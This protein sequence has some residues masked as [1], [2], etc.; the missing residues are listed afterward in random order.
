MKRVSIFVVSILLAS[1]LIYAQNEV[2]ALRYSRQATVGTARSV[3]LAGAIGAIGADFSSLSVNPAGIALYRGSELTISPSLF[4]D[5]TSSS[6]LGNSYEES[7]YNFNVGNLG[8][9][10][11]YDFNKEDGWIST[12]FGIGYNRNANFN[13][14]ILMSGLNQ[15][16]SLLDN[17]TDFANR[18]PN[19]L[20][21]FYEQLA[22]DIYLLPFDT[23]T[24]EFWNDIQNAGYGQHQ[25]R[26]LDTRGSSGEYTFSFG[27]NYNHRLYLGATFGI[28]R[29]RYEQ[30][31]IHSE[32]DLDNA[33]EF[34]DKFIFRENLRTTGTGYTFKLGG[35]IRPLDFLR[36]GFSY[37]LPVFYN[38]NDRFTT[39]MEG[40]YDPIENIQPKTEYSPLGDYDYKLKTPSKFVA[41][42]AATI[43][44]IGLVSVDYERTDFS[45]A[46]LNSR[47]YDFF[48]E[49]DAIKSLYNSTNN[50]RIGGEFRLG[51]AYL[52]GGYAIY[53]S[54]Y[55]ST[56]PNTKANKNV[57]AAGL[58]MRSRFMFVDF[59]YS[60][61]NIEEVYYM[62]VPQ[63]VNGSKNK[64]LGNN[65]IVT[66]GYKF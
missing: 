16:S 64:S 20:S 28:M 46:K 9:V 31:I 43:G 59:G 66:I 8:F 41:S 35:I 57:Y 12:S 14:S 2:D 27:A 52:R 19:N 5:N 33:I 34:F 24:N 49:N 30:D 25:R 45:G 51:A 40:Y 29:L 13:R 39:E 50:F 60:L 55:I 32:Q 56:E 38:L 63:M 54:P 21:S 48:D 47:E 58:G 4:W 22:Y 37:H 65:M 7:K 11:T 23:V 62:Y 15:N 17:F 3:G 10:S 1:S 26:I 6:F 36:L 61:S 42:L 44:K 53:Q 18:Y